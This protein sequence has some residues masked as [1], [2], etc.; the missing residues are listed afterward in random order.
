MAGAHPNQT[1]MVETQDQAN[2][3]MRLLQEWIPKRELTIHEIKVIA[4]ELRT[5]KQDV[6]IAKVVGGA[7]AVAGG[8]AAVA[9]TILTG[10][11]AAPLLVGGI[12]GAVT[13]GATS[14]GAEIAEKYISKDKLESAQNVLNE[15]AELS[16]RI[17][18]VKLKLDSKTR[19]LSRKLN[20]NFEQVQGALLMTTMIGG[21]FI[22]ENPV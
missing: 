21:I 8:V 5:V 9:G 16:K 1:L 12:A 7:V 3:Y 13:G 6:N 15:D 2:E 11:L 22:L 20:L 10:G 18:S 4:R 19:E 17:E 14:A